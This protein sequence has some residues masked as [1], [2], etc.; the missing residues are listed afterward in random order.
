[1]ALDRQSLIKELVTRRL[2]VDPIT[3]KHL[4]A[5][6]LQLSLGPNLAK[7]KREWWRLWWQKAIDPARGIGP[8]WTTFQLHPTK[9]YKLNPGEFALGHTLEKLTIPR[10]LLGMIDGKSS[11][12]RIGL[13]PHQAAMAIWPGHGDGPDGPRSI[14]LELKNLG[15]RPIILRTGMFLANLTLH[16]LECPVE[17]G[18]DQLVTSKY[19]GDAG[20]MLPRFNGELIDLGA[21]ISDVSVLL[22]V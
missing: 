9:G 5:A 20:I 1:M 8:E 18:Y 16:R 10:N 21:V 6:G 15:D 14:T 2:V 4:Q 11:M 7:M 13:P 12:A 22:H 19:S 3:P 17:T